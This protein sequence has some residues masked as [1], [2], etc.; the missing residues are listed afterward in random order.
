MLEL[1]KEN[2]F[3][4]LGIMVI[5]DV[6][7]V[8]VYAV[9]AMKKDKA[10]ALKRI[11]ILTAVVILLDG[12]CGIYITKMNTFYDRNMERYSSIQDVVYYKTNGKAYKLKDGYFVSLD[13]TDMFT[14][15]KAYV[16]E[17]GFL[18]YDRDGNIHKTELECFYK[19]DAGNKYYKATEVKWNSKGEAG[20]I[21]N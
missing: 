16:T 8:A 12:A 5:A 19:D 10:T 4:L 14:A 18:V 7:G 3:S 20:I 9:C 2:P 15:E 11:L 21:I 1:I 6:I 17:D 13:G